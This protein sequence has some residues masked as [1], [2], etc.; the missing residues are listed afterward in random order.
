MPEQARH[1]ISGGDAALYGLRNDVLMMSSL[2]GEP[3]DL[4]PAISFTRGIPVRLVTG[5]RSYPRALLCLFSIVGHGI[6]RTLRSRSSF[7]GENP[8]IY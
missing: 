3:A 5:I 2:A 8:S 7:I 6:H 4:F 1:I